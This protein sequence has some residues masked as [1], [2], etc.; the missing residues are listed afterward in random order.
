MKYFVPWALARTVGEWNFYKSA[1]TPTAVLGEGFYMTDEYRG[2]D[3]YYFI[4]R[5][6]LTVSQ[7]TAADYV[8]G[9]LEDWIEGALAF[10]GRRVATLSQ[11]EMTKDMNYSRGR[12]RRTYDGSKRE[13]VDMGTQRLPH[14]GRLQDGPRRRR[15]LTGVEARPVRLR[16]ERGRRRRAAACPAGRRSEGHGRLHRQ[17]QRR[18]VAPRHRRGGPRGRQGHV[19]R[20]RARRR[21][22][23]PWR[24]SR[25]THRWPTRPTSSW[26]RD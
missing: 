15:R 17:G 14:R 16:P 2:R 9:A 13:T 23:A 18:P 8:P 25:R 12:G 24:R 10:D 11:A 3:M 20:G 1:T 21:A 4:P 6:D 5:N 26:A 19:L 7:C 22:R